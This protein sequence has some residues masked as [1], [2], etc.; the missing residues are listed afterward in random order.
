MEAEPDQLLR[1]AMRVA[2]TLR[3]HEVHF[4]LA[5]GCAVYAHGGPASEHDVD[6]F[7]TEQDAPEARKVLV[8]AGMRAVNPPED[9]LLKV[10]DGD[11]LVDLIFR[12][13]G[14]PVTP[15]RL[16]RAEELRVGATTAPVIPATDLMVDKLLILNAHRCDF[17]PLLLIARAVR[18][19]IDWVEVSRQTGHSPYARAFLTL[20]A[21]LDIVDGRQLAHAKGEAHA[22]QGPW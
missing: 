22:E 4:A 7:V 17:A 12:P 10:Y 15:E 8:A 6:V 21:D 3:S 13:S 9:W 2:N 16:D 19:K 5:G 20:L 18:E 11:C 14:R 1:T